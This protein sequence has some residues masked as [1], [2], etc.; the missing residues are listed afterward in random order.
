MDLMKG[1]RLSWYMSGQPTFELNVREAITRY[2][3]RFG[4]M[5]TLVMANAVDVPAGCSEV[6]GVPVV[7]DKET[8]KNHLYV[9][10]AKA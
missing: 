1:L 2:R 4:Q 3:M 10:M 9:G 7:I 5:P 6:D 8:M